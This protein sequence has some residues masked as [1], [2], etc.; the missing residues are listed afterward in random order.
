MK[1]KRLFALGLVLLM[2]F[3]FVGCGK[4]GR[5]I[6]EVTLSTEDAEA[7]LAAAGI[8]L[9]DAESTVAA[10]STIKWFSWYD[11]FHNYDEAEI[12]NTGYFTFKEKYGCELQ[13]VETTWSARFDELA[14]LILGG[15]AP[16]F[17]PSSNE[18]FPTY[19]IKGMFMPVDDYVD[20]DDPLW[21]DMRTSLT[22]TSPWAESIT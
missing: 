9:P 3:A 13:W 15:T 12:V 21:A 1:T 8:T 5:Q 16:D 18:T 2:I 20:Y 10:G 22:N 19:A 7:I 6:V 17:Y 14:T 4:S 11:S